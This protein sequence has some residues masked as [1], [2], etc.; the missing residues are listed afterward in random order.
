MPESERHQLKKIKD[1]TRSLVPKLDIS[2]LDPE[3][4]LQS[5]AEFLGSQRDYLVDLFFS[6]FIQKMGSLPQ[7]PEEIYLESPRQPRTGV[8]DDRNFHLSESF[9]DWLDMI[10]VLKHQNDDMEMHVINY[11]SHLNTIKDQKIEDLSSL[12]QEYEDLKREIEVFD[13]L[14]VVNNDRY[15]DFSGNTELVSLLRHESRTPLTV[16][17]GF[18]TTLSADDVSWDSAAQKEFSGLI[19]QDYDR[20]MDFINPLIEIDFKDAWFRSCPISEIGRFL[21]SRWKK[22]D[23][24][25][26]GATQGIGRSE[27]IIQKQQIFQHD[28]IGE[29]YVY[30]SETLTQFLVYN[31]FTNAY[32]SVHRKGI[33]T[34]QIDLHEELDPKKGI[35]RM[36]IRDNGEGFKIGYGERFD[37]EEGKG[38]QMPEGMR[39][40][41]IGM[42]RFVDVLRKNTKKSYLKKTAVYGQNWY[43]EDRNIAGGEI[44]LELPLVKSSIKQK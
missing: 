29:G 16:I 37:F 9:L 23:L 42:A 33:D 32:K 14:T 13:R 11:V 8:A 39:S 2:F 4:A 19:I 31:I 34:L 35:Y 17:L 26:L 28:Q 21:C 44:V 15:V 22:L 5:D 38:V 36:R 24:K 20:M 18:I 41:K 30:F 43:D 25:A 10:N 40:E 12:K 27:Q 6:R 3:I 1:E 7:P